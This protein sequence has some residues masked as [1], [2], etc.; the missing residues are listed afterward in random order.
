MGGEGEPRGR[1]LNELT[2]LRRRL[3]EAER[4]L[5]ELASAEAECRVA[6]EALRDSQSELSIVFD[7]VPVAMMLVDQERR[8]RKANRAA[9]KFSG[10]QAD[11]MTGLRAGEALR[12][13]RSLDD[14][15][16]CGFGP[17]CSECVVR[18]A[19]LYTIETGKSHCQV[20]APLSLI[21][22]EVQAEVHLLV[23]TT[24][25]DAMESRMVLVCVEDITTHRRADKIIH[26]R[27]ELFEFAADHSLEA[28]MQKALD[29]IGEITNSPIG[30]YHFVET[31]QKTLSLQAWSTRTLQEFCQAEGR[32]L[33]Y[34]I[35]QAGV[36][37]DCV[38][39]RQPVI[40]NDYA[41]LSHRKGM[42]PGHAEVKRELVVPTMRN[43]RIVSILG[44]GNKPSDYDEKDV[45]LVAYAADVIWSIIE[46]KRDEEQLQG[47]Q[48]QLEA[49]NLELRK[50]SLAIE[51]SGSIIV[52][53]D[54]DGNIQY[55]NPRFEETT[56][57]TSSEALGQNPRIL[58][59]GEQDAE[60]YKVL[61]DTISSGQIWR[62]E[63]HNR[64]KDGT[65]YWESAT[66][67]PVHNSAGQITSYIAIKEDITEHR[68][69]E[70]AL[71]QYAAELESRNEELDAFAHT[72][73]HDLKNPLGLLIGYADILAMDYV[74][75]MPEDIEKYIQAIARNGRRMGRIIDELLLLAS[76]RQAEVEVKP[77]DMEGAARESLQRLVDMIEEYRAEII[78]PESWPVAL[79]YGPWIEEVW[80]N[81][82]NNAIKYG[83]RPPRV[84]L[85]AEELP[86]DR[87]R[88]WVHDNGPGL[89]PEEQGRLF[90]PF[91]R[92]DQAHTK[93]HGL[94]LSIVRRIVE[95]LDGAVGVDSKEG[96]GSIFSFTLP[97]LPETE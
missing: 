4:R 96:K 61:W 62:G 38:H 60:Y 21:R 92:L 8:V 27:L 94:G 63:F 1:N 7:N 68:Q 88:F 75:L 85:G 2:E 86:D 25:I 47:Y 89:S 90:R 15:R 70:E 97:S 36:W 23:S 30:F 16:G 52:I 64:R 32:G 33:H 20:E 93:G 41:A 84:E 22:D 73:A 12:C 42:P 58:K 19:V 44:V 78:L 53:T 79:G 43:G 18:R 91:T 40:H 9:I 65:L 5:E 69:A 39:Q 13:I 28:L 72:A 37:V 24:P 29:E 31:D 26:L 57:Y 48:Q 82:V 49:Q 17:S 10:H 66:I 74:D 87:V 51:Q 6:E 67:A 46:R 3:A 50:L 54:T 59:S 81:Y 71:R 35:D 55:V 80:A 11:E 77:V 34:D 95:K 14:P 76:V 83:G 56:G 45:K